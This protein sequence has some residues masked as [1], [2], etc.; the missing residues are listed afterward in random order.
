MALKELVPKRWGRSE[1][2][3]THEEPFYTLKHA[4]D[5]MFE[6]IDRIFY[7]VE[8]ELEKRPFWERYGGEFSPRIDAI[9]HDKEFIVK[10]ELPGMEEKDIDL[11]LTEDSL[12]IKGEKK[13]EKEEYYFMERSYGSFIRTIPLPSRIETGKVEAKFHNGILTITLPK[14][15]ESIKETKKIPIKVV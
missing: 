7:D 1:L 12:I 4:M 3:I 9:E 2:P 13:L 14:T 11:K 10:V 8:H 6:R 15:P 5:R